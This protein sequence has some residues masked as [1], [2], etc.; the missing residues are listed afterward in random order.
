MVGKD[1]EYLIARK[2]QIERRQRIL[3]IVSMVSF[4]GSIGFSAI[5]SI[6]QAIQNPTPASAYVSPESALKEQVRGYELVLQREPENQ[7]ALEKL[8]LLRLELKDAK[9]AMEPLEKL[10]K[11]HPDR[12]DYKIV[13]EKIKKQESKGDRNTNN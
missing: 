4:F 9:G 2:K 11:L 12:Q 3:T 5:P 1:E 13:L 10:I 8:S 6:Q 7:M